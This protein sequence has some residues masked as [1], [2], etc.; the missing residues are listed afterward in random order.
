MVRQHQPQSSPREGMHAQ[1]YLHIYIYIYHMNTV[2]CG[3]FIQRR[4]HL[5]RPKLCQGSRATAYLLGNI[6][7]HVPYQERRRDDE[8]ASRRRRKGNP[9][10]DRHTD[11][12][13]PPKVFVQGNV[14]RAVLRDSVLVQRASVLAVSEFTSDITIRLTQKGIQ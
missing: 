5:L 11:I 1:K 13:E 9:A 6:G 10:L 8:S 14:L 3:A 4:C 2:P 7:V 12:I